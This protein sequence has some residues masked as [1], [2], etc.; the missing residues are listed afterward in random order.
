MKFTIAKDRTGTGRTTS[1]LIG[2]TKPS[3][4]SVDTSDVVLRN[5]NFKIIFILFDPNF[6]NIFEFFLTF[7]SQGREIMI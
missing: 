3:F 5:L 6:L 1:D 4:S 7:E 2:S